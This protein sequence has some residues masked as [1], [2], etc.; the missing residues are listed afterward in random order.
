M[1]RV[2]EAQAEQVRLGGQANA[3]RIRAQGEAEADALARRADAYR[4]FNEAAILQAILSELPKIVAAAAQPLG[5]IDNLTVLSSDGATEV[6]RTGTRTVAEASAAIKGLTGIDLPVLIGGAVNRFNDDNGGNGGNRGGAGRRN[7]SGN[8]KAKGERNG[9]EE[10]AGAA[11]EATADAATG[12]SAQATADAA[13]KPVP[14]QRATPSAAAPAA[15]QVASA[16]QA[17]TAAAAATA[18]PAL[19]EAVQ[20]VGSALKQLPGIERYRSVRLVN[21]LNRAGVTSRPTIEWA[22]GQLP[23]EAHQYTVGDLLDQ[24]G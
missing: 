4:E 8:G 12:E 1:I 21:L 2:A 14:A 17:A 16:A 15:A 13:A 7:G 9:T 23:P 10:E 5:Q 18:S 24:A 3:D 20:R 19:I 22:L 6:V 11:P